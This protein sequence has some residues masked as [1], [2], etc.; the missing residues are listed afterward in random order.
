MFG[1]A[2]TAYVYRSYGIHWCLNFVIATTKPE[3]V[4]RILNAGREPET[5]ESLALSG[6]TAW[7][8][9]V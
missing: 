7:R 9:V 4:E 3:L 2:G 6:H 5:P 1:A 8:G